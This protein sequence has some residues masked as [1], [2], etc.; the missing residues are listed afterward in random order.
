MPDAVEAQP[1]AGGAPAAE[2]LPSVTFE[3][4][5][6]SDGTTVQLDPTDI[7]VFIG[8]NNAGKSAALRELE[9]FV[10]PPTAPDGHQVRTPK[11]SWIAGAGAGLAGG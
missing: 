2:Q 4:L 10:G 9:L 1:A 8:P 7:V 6:F 5:T 3:S 11:K